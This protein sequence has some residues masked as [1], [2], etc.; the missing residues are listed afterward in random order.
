MFFWFRR[1][2]VE[3]IETSQAPTGDFFQEQFQRRKPST[4]DN[5]NLRKEA[6]GVAKQ[7]GSSASRE[8]RPGPDYQALAEKMRNEGLNGQFEELLHLYYEKGLDE[9]EIAERTARG[10][11]EVGLVIDY[12]DRLR[13]DMNHGKR[14]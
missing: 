11:G 2:R 6:E 12:A 13:K 5:R 3:V 4:L 8:D 9:D 1:R 10:L 7:A 14:A